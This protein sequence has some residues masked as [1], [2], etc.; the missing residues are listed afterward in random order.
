MGENLKN[1]RLGLFVIVG[2]VLLIS[3][4]YFI[5]SKQSLFSDTVTI[6]ARFHNVNGLMKGNN[7]RFSGIDVGTVESVD[8]ISDSMVEVVMVIEMKAQ[9]YIK[10]NAIASIGTDGLMGNK[11]VNINSGTKAAPSIE[12]DAVLQTLRPIEMD[13]MI[14]TLNETNE[15][16]MVI[17]SNLRTI[18][19]K[20]NNKNSLWN[21]L[22]D[23]MVAENV[24][25]SIVNLKVMS[26][27]GVLVTGDLRNILAGIQK[28]KGSLGALITDTTLSSKINQTVVKL[29]RL[30][31]TAAVMTG[32]L[33]YVIKGLK[34]GKG[35]IGVLLNDTSLIHNLN[36]SVGTLKVG[37]GNFNESMEALKHSW[38][39]KKYFKKIKNKK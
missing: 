28:G 1:I 29:E 9:P 36:Q 21:I 4:F 37:A 13:E 8:I 15:N 12:D 14:R 27:T 26:N 33:S 2:T 10:T 34:Q 3:A 24:K 39:F 6:S 25:T 38:P 7:V 30:S 17:S 5:G 20:I 19:D 35:T 22:M 18:T 32:D 23:T 16:I 31:D 11:L